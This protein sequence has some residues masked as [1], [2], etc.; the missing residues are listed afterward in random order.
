M[1]NSAASYLQ[2]EATDVAASR[3]AFNSAC[4]AAEG[5]FG[6]GFMQKCF[7]DFFQAWFAALDDQAQTL[8]SVADATQQCAVIYDHAER[9]T[10]GD[11]PA[12]AVPKPP[13]A[14]PPQQQGP[15]L[16]GPPPREVA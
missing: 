10:L 4:Y 11:I 15:S 14:S 1:L 13:P 2:G 12:M 6:G 16:F 7:N 9:E 3:D 8:G 5:A